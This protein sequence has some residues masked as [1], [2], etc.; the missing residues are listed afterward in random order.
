MIFRPSP[1]KQTARKLGAVAD[2]SKFEAGQWAY[3]VQCS[4]NAIWLF[5]TM[6]AAKAMAEYL[7]RTDKPPGSAGSFMRRDG[8]IDLFETLIW[9]EIGA[10]PS[11]S[12]V[13][14]RE[15]GEWVETWCG[16]AP[17]VG[18][19]VVKRKAETETPTGDSTLFPHTRFSS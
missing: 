2:I 8:R 3:R 19:A 13:W 6:Q 7:V 18:A 17:G 9:P 11:R 16:T 12:F 1:I 10:I 15:D 5:G 4:E 14:S